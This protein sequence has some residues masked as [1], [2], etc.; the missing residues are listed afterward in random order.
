MIPASQLPL[1]T[2]PWPPL[3]LSITSSS[4]VGVPGIPISHENHLLLCSALEFD[5]WAPTF[6]SL[7]PSLSALTLG[8]LEVEDRRVDHS[9]AR[10]HSHAA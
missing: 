6:R 1:Q 3:A 5:R 7:G 8:Q 10:V 9:S 4:W 2:L